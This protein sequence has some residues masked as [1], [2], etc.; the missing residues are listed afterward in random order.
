MSHVFSSD[1]KIKINKI[2]QIIQKSSNTILLTST[3]S[4]HTRLA[5]ILMSGYSSDGVISIKSSSDHFFDGDCKSEL[6]FS[7][8][9]EDTKLDGSEGTEHAE[10]FLENQEIDAE[11][12]TDPALRGMGFIFIAYPADRFAT[13]E[14]RQAG[15]KLKIKLP[16]QSARK[17]LVQAKDQVE[18]DTKKSVHEDETSEE[19]ES[20]CPAGS[21]QK[22]PWCKEKIKSK[23]KRKHARKHSQLTSGGEDMEE[24]SEEEMT[25]VAQSPSHGHPQARRSHGSR[26]E[27]S[28]DPVA[29]P[30]KRSR[31]RKIREETP[32]SHTS[33]NVPVYVEIAVPPKL[34]LGRT[35]K[36]NKMEK[37]EP[38]ME[39]PFTLTRRMTWKAFLTAISDTVD[40]DLE[41]LL[42][43]DMKWGLQKK[44]R[45]PLASHAGYMAMLKQI[46]AQ[47]VPSAMIIMVYLPIPRVPKRKRQRQDQDEDEDQ[48][49]DQDNSRWGQKVGYDLWHGC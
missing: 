26:K 25:G 34:K 46:T 21:P 22:L 5:A 8:G 36:G 47:R 30:K 3:Q 14:A 7:W 23:P 20:E 39:G 1:R 11:S 40:E 31:P 27:P 45:Y 35:H 38:R 6:P 2:I 41:N 13:E 49:V 19:S 18:A 48:D 43:E 15:L 32:L 10:R 44:I 29:V 24:S 4:L 28:E 9:D 16:A 17:A 12:D 37:Q 33:L 42:I